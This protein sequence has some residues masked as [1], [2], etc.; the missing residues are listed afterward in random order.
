MRVLMNMLNSYEQIWFQLSDLGLTPPNVLLLSS[1][2]RLISLVLLICLSLRLSTFVGQNIKSTVPR[3][4]K[5]GLAVDRI[6]RSK[7]IAKYVSR[8]TESLQNN[9]QT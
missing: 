2:R 1:D 8:P 6:P 7:G 3:L 4:E 5:A 9:S